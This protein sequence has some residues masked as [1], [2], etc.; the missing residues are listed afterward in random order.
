MRGMLAGGAGPCRQ[1][2]PQ[3]LPYSF[4]EMSFSCQ[5]MDPQRVQGLRYAAGTMG[6][7]QATSC[8]CWA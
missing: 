6:S 2:G 4:P 8:R 7:H 3:L 1:P 5:R